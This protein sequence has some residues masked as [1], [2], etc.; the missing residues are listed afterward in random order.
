[1]AIQYLH[2][3]INIATRSEDVDASEVAKFIAKSDYDVHGSVAL[4]HTL[5]R[6]CTRRNAVF[7]SI[8]R[9]DAT[10]PSHIAEIW[11]DL[12][13]QVTKDC[14]T[15]PEGRAGLQGKILELING[16]KEDGQTS[17]DFL[18]EVSENLRPLLVDA[19]GSHGPLSSTCSHPNFS[20]SN[21]FS[22]LGSNFSGADLV[23]AVDDFEILD[24]PSVGYFDKVTDHPN[25][26]DGLTSMSCQLDFQKLVTEKC[27]HAYDYVAKNVNPNRLKA[28]LGNSLS[29]FSTGALNQNCV[30]CAKAVER[31]LE[32]MTSGRL[33]KFWV[34]NSTGSGGLPQNVLTKNYTEISLT[35]ESLSQ[36]LLSNVQEKSRNIIVVPVRGRDFSHAMNLVHSGTNVMIIDGQFGLVYDFGSPGGQRAFEKRYGLGNGIN[37]LRIYRTGDAP[38]VSTLGHLEKSRGRWHDATEAEG[39]RM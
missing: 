35:N 34:A 27:A 39:M 25:F 26:D 12:S 10:L 36:Q 13:D 24:N 8:F 14:E 22:L 18:E 37:V 1:M 7:D 5:I 16:A 20:R 6:L 19:G 28:M 21:S 23:G 32:A 15:F 17:A 31:N 38:P 4:A 33:D 30:I 11:M 3:K 2:Q 29:Y 9:G